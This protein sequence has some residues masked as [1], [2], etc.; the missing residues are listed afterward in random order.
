[1]VV[2]PSQS[3]KKTVLAESKGLFVAGAGIHPLLR[4]LF[5]V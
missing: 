5:F 3:N 2:S 1:M 4:V